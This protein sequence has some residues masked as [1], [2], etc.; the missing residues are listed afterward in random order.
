LLKNASICWRCASTVTLSSTF[1]DNSCWTE[2]GREGGRERR[3]GGRGMR[4]GGGMEREREREGE[5]RE[6]EGG[7]ER[8]GRE[9]EGWREKGMRMRERD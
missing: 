1:A 7:I 8:G 4:D 5:G 6:N 3:D 2:G 9:R